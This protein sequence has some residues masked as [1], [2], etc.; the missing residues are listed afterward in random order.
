MTLEDDRIVHATAKLFGVRCET[1]KRLVDDRLYWS[2]SRDYPGKLLGQGDRS[3]VTH[4]YDRE[5]AIAWI[6]NM[7]YWYPLQR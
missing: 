7:A 2:L 1:Q 6:A 3:M 5:A 4:C